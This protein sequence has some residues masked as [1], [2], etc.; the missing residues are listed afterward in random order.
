MK[1]SV[2]TLL[3]CAQL[4]PPSH[5]SFLIETPTSIVT[6]FLNVCF[7]FVFFYRSDLRLVIVPLLSRFH[8]NS[9]PGGSLL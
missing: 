4:F 2:F 7:F 1:A 8:N 9:T 6:H 3:I 5:N